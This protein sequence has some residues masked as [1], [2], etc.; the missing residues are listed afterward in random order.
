VRSVSNE[1]EQL[2]WHEVESYLK[3][4]QRLA[5]VLGSTE[6]HGHLSLST[7]TLTALH[8][9]RLATAAEGVLLAP[10]LHFGN[11]SLLSAWPGTL[12]IGVETY[13]RAVVDL[14]L[15]AYNSGFRRLFFFNGHAGNSYVVNHLHE[16]I[17]TKSDLICDFFEWAADPGVADL[18]QGIR[19]GGLTHAN[20]AENWPVSRVSGHPVPE[21]DVPWWGY[22][23]SV[24]LYAP[25]DFRANAPSGSFGGPGQIDDAELQPLIDLAVSTARAR[26]RSLADDSSGIP[27]G[28]ETSNDRLDG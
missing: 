10:P 21:A 19:P 28:I 2:T 7:D 23:R 12:S 20:W 13:A 27:A 5:F 3:K 4:D 26:L 18:A 22:T 9:A 14:A 15:S 8:V 1:L 17:A 16:L 24:F 25:A 11:A 6:Q